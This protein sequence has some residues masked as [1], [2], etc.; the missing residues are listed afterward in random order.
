MHLRSSYLL[1]VKLCLMAGYCLRDIQLSMRRR[2][3]EW[4]LSRSIEAASSSTNRLLRGL[5]P[6]HVVRKLQRKQRYLGESCRIVVLF[7]DISGFT[8]LS[9][10]MGPRELVLILHQVAH[11]F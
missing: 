11:L 6:E 4:L 3:A 8:P 7:S 9:A 2:R 10:S 1:S 5:L